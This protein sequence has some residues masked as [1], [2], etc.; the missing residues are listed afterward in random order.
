MQPILL[1]LAF[2]LLPRADAAGEKGQADHSCAAP[3]AT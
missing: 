3:Q 1:L 2:L